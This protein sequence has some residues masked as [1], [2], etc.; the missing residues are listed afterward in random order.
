ML[1]PPR[2]TGPRSPALRRLET[3]HSLLSPPGAPAAHCYPWDPNPGLEPALT[4]QGP[5]P[6]FQAS[7]NWVSRNS[8][9][10]VRQTPLTLRL[11]CV[12]GRKRDDKAAT[13]RPVLSAKGVGSPWITSLSGCAEVRRGHGEEF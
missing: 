9:T 6:C 8:P 3:L 5:H 2:V 13:E 10:F 7:G 1:Q 12:D 11:R 4:P